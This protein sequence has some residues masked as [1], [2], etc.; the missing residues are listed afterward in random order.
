M[1]P[2]AG[3][4]VLD[5]S[6]VIAGPLCAQY[7]GDL[8][9]E[10]IK[11][12]PCIGGDDTR[13]WPPLRGDTGA[14]FLSLNRNKQSLA[15]DLKAPAAQEIVR[16]LV[17]RSD[18]VIESYAPSVK[19]RLGV[20]YAQLKPHR[21]GLVY[22]SISGFGQTGPL[23]DALGYDN[24][25]QA[26][27]GVMAM[28]GEPDAGPTRIPI[29]PIDQATGLN[30]A[31][32]ILAALMNR[33]ATG[34]GASLEVSLFETAVSML[35]FTLQGYWESGKIPARL[36][37]AHGSI[38]PY[39]IFETADRPVLL[40]IANDR[41]WR[42]FCA[43]TGRKA[44]GDDPRF[45]TNVDRV[46]HFAETVGLVQEV[47]RTRSSSEW[48]AA[49]GAVDVPCTPVNT[50]KDL[51][52]HA[53][54]AARGI[55]QSFGGAAGGLKTVAM[56][57]QF[58]GRPREAGRPPPGHG[59]DSRAILRAIGCAEAEI[60]RLIDAGVVTVPIASEAAA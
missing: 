19:T 57:I 58:D 39:Q 11:V 24:I 13:D 51:D 6:K 33:D 12:E 2:L 21:P 38:C 3:K 17:A 32:G 49:L 50:V 28:N 10:I 22:C 18:V 53:H 7:L 37:S 44:L 4:T 35:G 36:G 59:Q 56:P 23:R 45:K 15:L 5:F 41:L 14:V 30:A 27:T 26:F 8:G 54:M 60:D 47:M 16:K 55:V 20:D 46:R 25:L 34:E 31:I 9:A 29:S 1:K 43:A 48:V 52:E 42:R 40:G